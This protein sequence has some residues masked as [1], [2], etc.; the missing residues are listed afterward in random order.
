[1]CAETVP[2]SVE[3]LLSPIQVPSL[4]HETLSHGLAHKSST[5]LHNIATGVSNS[6]I[7]IAPSSVVASL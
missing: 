7:Y 5:S 3:P 6:S 2:S 1:M 4:Q